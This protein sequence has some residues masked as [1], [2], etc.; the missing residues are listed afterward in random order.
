MNIS[1]VIPVYNE[2]KYIEQCL[3]CIFKQSKK[4]YEIIVVDNNSTDQSANII[5]KY[6][7][8]Y[9]FEKKQGIIHARNAGFNM[10]KGDII[11]RTD[12][13]TLLP[14]NWIE[15]IEQHFF[16]VKTNALSGGFIFYDAYSKNKIYSTVYE[17]LMHMFIKHNIFL[18]PNMILRKTLWEKV[19]N[20]I[21]LDDKKVHEDLDLSIHLTSIGEEIIFDPSLTV[22]ISSRRIKSDPASFFIEYFFRAIKT[23][24]SHKIN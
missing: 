11:A 18:G 3:S 7:V 12:A 5:K 22:Q 16:D 4:P 9:I 19:K 6:P 24:Q 15:K 20:Y 2:E 1:V 21:C 23:I 14:L 17:K 13:D 10:A 8:I